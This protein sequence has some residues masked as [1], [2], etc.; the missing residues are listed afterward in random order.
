MNQEI[1]NT[2]K[3][4]TPSRL[5]TPNS[6][7]A[8]YAWDEWLKSNNCRQLQDADGHIWQLL[9]LEEKLPDPGHA[10]GVWKVTLR[11]VSRATANQ[12]ATT[13]V[14][15]PAADA[16]LIAMFGENKVT[17]AMKPMSYTS[18]RIEDARVWLRDQLTL[19]RRRLLNPEIR[20][21]KRQLATRWLSESRIFGAQK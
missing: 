7:A 2:L 1:Y 11:L 20:R 4:Q 21:V 9:L 3:P 14:L 16:R 6:H 17:F 8:A 5:M 19:A 15:D 12:L 10:Q 13:K 18:S